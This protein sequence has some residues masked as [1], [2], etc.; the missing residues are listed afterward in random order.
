MLLKIAYD[1]QEQREREQSVNSL[2]V[3]IHSNFS[4]NKLDVSSFSLDVK[5]ETSKVAVFR[6]KNTSLTASSL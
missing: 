5:S 3:G 4:Q 6:Q 2:P 1:L